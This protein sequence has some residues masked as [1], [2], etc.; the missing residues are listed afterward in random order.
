MTRH[1]TLL[2]TDLA[3]EEN[4]GCVP[5]NEHLQ[6]LVNELTEE[7]FLVQLDGATHA[8]YTITGKGISEANRLNETNENRS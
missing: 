5:N 8:T 6:F 3:K 4:L 1:E 7:G 2:F